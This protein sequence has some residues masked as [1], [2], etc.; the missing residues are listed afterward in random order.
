V[1]NLNKTYRFNA[2]NDLTEYSGE[3]GSF[4]RTSRSAFVE[5]SFELI[6]FWRREASS[7]EVTESVSMKRLLHIVWI[8]CYMLIIAS[9]IIEI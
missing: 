6:N 3:F 7:L 5:R 4:C 8:S 9:T 2:S 1:E